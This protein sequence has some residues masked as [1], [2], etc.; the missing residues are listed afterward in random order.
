MSNDIHID[1]RSDLLSP[2]NTSAAQAVQSAISGQ[3]SFGLREDRFQ[4]RLECEIAELLG[5]EDALLFPSCGMA[6]LVAAMLVQDRARTVLVPQDCHVLTSEGAGISAIAGLMPT[7]LPGHF[8]SLAQWEAAM[9]PGDDLRPGPALLWLEN[10]HNRSGGD[11]LSTKDSLQI[12]QLAKEQGIRTHLDGS[13]LFNAAIALQVAPAR[14]ADGFDTVAVS[15]NKGLGAPAG[16]IL[17]GDSASI[18]AAVR[19]RQMLGGGL[20]PTALL[21]APAL[22]A[23]DNWQEIALD[24]ANATVLWNEIGHLHGF[25]CPRPQTNIVLLKFGPEAC[26]TP[27]KLRR[28]LEEH[29]IHCLVF[30]ENSLR[31]VMHRGIT[32]KCAR[33][34]AATV[35]SIINDYNY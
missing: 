18:R 11:V 19:I 23:L 24:H 20:R 13:R 4:H 6:N 34:V 33:Y 16:A 10:T 25:E 15:L 17:A 9:Q 32:S 5:K 31:F 8:P 26:Q 12:T 3:L 27:E 30:G 1:L 28:Q 21:C 14:I 7:V 29:G 2:L 22:A 35:R